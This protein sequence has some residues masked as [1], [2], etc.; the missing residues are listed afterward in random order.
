M[1]PFSVSF[2]V[3]TGNIRNLMFLVSVLISNINF[4]W[5]DYFSHL[6]FTM[7]FIF[8]LCNWYISPKRIQYYSVIIYSPSCHFKHEWL[9]LVEHTHTHTHTHTLGNYLV[10]EI[11]NL[12]D[13]PIIF[14]ISWFL[15]TLVTT[16]HKMEKICSFFNPVK[17]KTKQKRALDK[18]FF[19]NFQ[20]T[21]CF[22]F[23]VCKKKTE[24]KEHRINKVKDKFYW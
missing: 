13:T 14:Q 12:V 5:L 2:L 9:S 11:C 19:M 17:N 16:H 18:T 15:N 8:I 22:F 20:S 6:T 3:E 1:I 21:V 10:F 4:G 7:K 24:R 23:L